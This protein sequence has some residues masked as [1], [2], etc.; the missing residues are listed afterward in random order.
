[1][2]STSRAPELSATLS[3]LSCWITTSPRPSPAL[4][5]RA[6][7]SASTAGGSR[8][9][10]RGRPRG[11]RSPRRA[12]RALRALQRLAVAAV[13]HAVDD[14]DDDRLVHLR[15][16]DDALPHL[17]RVGARRRRSSSVIVGSSLAPRCLG[18]RDLA[19]AQQRLDAGDLAPHLRR[20]ARV[21]SSWPVACWKRRLNSSSL[22]SR[23]RCSSSASLSSRSSLGFVHHASSC[24]HDEARLDRQLVHREPHRLA[25]DRLGH[26]GRARTSRGPGFTTATQCSGL[27]LPEPMRV[28]AGFCVTGLSGKTLIQ[29]FPPRLM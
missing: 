17:A 27:P 29:T 16:H 20:S 12:R 21:L 19:L 7:A 8:R 24:P 2:H 18:G 22:V 25:R 15:R 4:R 6:S 5:R 11:R 13:P 23:S 14:R 1:M 10:A 26:T 3:R 28:S 9:C